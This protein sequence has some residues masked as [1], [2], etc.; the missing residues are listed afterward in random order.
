MFEGVR[1]L[2]AASRGYRLRPGRSPYLRWRFE[3]YTG[4]PAQSVRLRDFVWLAWNERGQ[5]IR[6]RRWLGELK[7][8]AEHSVNGG[9]GAR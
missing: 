3:T 2:Y 5:V 9:G 4:K 7:R 8:I 1:F 6:F